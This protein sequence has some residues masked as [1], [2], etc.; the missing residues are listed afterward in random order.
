MPK[1]LSNVEA[2][3]RRLSLATHARE[4]AYTDYW[5][6]PIKDC[7]GEGEMVYTSTRVIDESLV[8]CRFF[9]AG[10][11][12]LF[13]IEDAIKAAKSGKLKEFFETE[14]AIAKMSG[15]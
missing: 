10:Y 8:E 9:S 7:Y 5:W 1:Y 13:K 3:E 4:F 11:T 14:I 12:V 6:R 15:Q 2:L